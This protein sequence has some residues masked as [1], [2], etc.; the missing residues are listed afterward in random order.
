[1]AL[2]VKVVS[3]SH[4][5]NKKTVAHQHTMASQ[6]TCIHHC[7]QYWKVTIG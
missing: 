3:I 1:M 2:D 7:I 5:H 6:Q 4:C